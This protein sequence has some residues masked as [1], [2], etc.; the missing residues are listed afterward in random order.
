MEAKDAKNKTKQGAERKPFIKRDLQ[1]GF[2][3]SLV[4]AGVLAPRFFPRVERLAPV[5]GMVDSGKPGTPPPG[6]NQPVQLASVAEPIKAALPAPGTFSPPRKPAE[7]LTNVI[8]DGYV[9]KTRGTAAESKPLALTSPPPANSAGPPPLLP[10]LSQMPAQ[11]RDARAEA[12]AES[13]PLPT[14]AGSTPVKADA[15]V[16]EFVPFVEK[17]NPKAPEPIPEKPVL[18]EAT[19]KEPPLAPPGLLPFPKLDPEVVEKK[20]SAAASIEKERIPAAAA[21][22]SAAP[23]SPI[24]VPQTARAEPPGKQASFSAGAETAAPADITVQAF[25]RPRR[26]IPAPDMAKPVERTAR[27]SRVEERSTIPAPKAGQPGRRPIHPFY[28]R[29]L[30]EGEYFVRPGDTLRAIAERLYQ[31][32]SMVAALINANKS[33]LKQASD[34]RPGMRL[35]LP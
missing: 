11:R 34:L 10:N 22:R 14:A 19:K 30:D 9:A 4:L 23:S 26:E 3:L 18:T 12:L 33:Q 31:D 13:L 17:S 1:F 16:T 20:A 29:Y 21:P 27:S 6:A 5:T 32:E 28:Q 24:T 7:A 2:L 15:V 25:D 8:P 35:R